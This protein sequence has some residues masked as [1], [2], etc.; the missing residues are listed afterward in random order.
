MRGQRSELTKGSSSCTRS[1][2]AFCS[3]SARGLQ[4]RMLWQIPATWLHWGKRSRMS[5]LSQIPPAS[6][7]LPPTPYTY[8]PEDLALLLSCRTVL[9]AVRDLP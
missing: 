1:S 3:S 6:S 4:F 2:T 8:N 7:P 5:S 9:E